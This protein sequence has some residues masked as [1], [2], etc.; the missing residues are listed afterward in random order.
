M[1]PPDLKVPLLC[2]TSPDTSTELIC[3]H[4]DQNLSTSLPINKL[5]SSRGLKVVVALRIRADKTQ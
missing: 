4:L 3:Y 1:C 5:V 2:I